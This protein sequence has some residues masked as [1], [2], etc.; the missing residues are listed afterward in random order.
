MH[1][2]VR[3]LIPVDIGYITKTW[4]SSARRE[5]PY[6][7]MSKLAIKKYAERV[8]ALVEVSEVLVATDPEDPATLYGFICYENTPFLGKHTPTLHYIYVTDKFRRLGIATALFD[9]AFPVREPKMHYTHMTRSLRDAK[10]EKRWKLSD[11]DPYLIE[12]ALF[13]DSRDIDARATYWSQIPGQGGP[14]GRTGGTPPR[15]KL[16]P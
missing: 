2:P 15:Q 4:V 9:A 16:E 5:Y 7:N 6:R 14:L 8:R 12:G 1:F 3:P 13:K 10:L 11:Y